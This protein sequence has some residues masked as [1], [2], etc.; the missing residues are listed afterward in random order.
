MANKK[1]AKDA[2]V[3]G[4]N[5]RS[6]GLGG[7]KGMRGGAHADPVGNVKLRGEDPS[8][9]DRERGETARSAPPQP[10]R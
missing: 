2:K 4:G 7:G 9:D 10:G 6:S 5:R 1:Q 3:P 8:P